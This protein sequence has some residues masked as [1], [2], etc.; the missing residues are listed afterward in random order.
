MNRDKVKICSLNS[1]GLGDPRKRRDVLDHLRQNKYSIICLQDTHFTENI[2]HVIINEW[3]YKA[4]FNS[5]D[6]RSRGVAIFFRNDFEFKIYN[7]LKDHS[8][9]LLILDIEIEKHRIT[10]VNLYGPN[11]DDPSFYEKL[12]NNVTSFGNSDIIILGD[13]NML[14]NPAIDG[15]N[16]KHINNPNARQRVLKLMNDLNL[17][18]VWREENLEK[19]KFTWKRKLQPGVIQMGRLDFFLVSETL[20]NYSLEENISPGYR[21]DHSLISMSLQF[22]KSPRGRTFWKFNSSLLNNANYIDE[23]KD[24]ILNVKRQYAASPYNLKYQ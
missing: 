13:W 9:N 5:F 22:S 18:D 17:Y 7:T 21:S 2:E 15:L 16:Y 19:R 11:N 10:L 3:G 4:F 24:V 20:I 6:S 8:G 1:Q 23:I 12:Q 14:L